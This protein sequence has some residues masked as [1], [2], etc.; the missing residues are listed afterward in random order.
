MASKKTTAIVEPPVKPQ[1]PHQPKGRTLAYQGPKIPMS[2][3]SDKQDYSATPQDCIND[4]RRVA[5]AD[6]EQVISRN[7][8]RNVGKYSES[9]W[10]RFFGTFHEFKRQA[11]IVLTRQQHKLERETAKHAAHDHYRELN[12]IRADYAERFVRVNKSRY[13]TL[14]GLCDIHDRSCDPF[15]LRVALDAVKRIQP[16]VIC[17]NGDLFDLPEFG[18]YTVDP[19]EWDV[20]GRIKFV[21]ENVL[22]PLRKAAPNAQIDLVEGNHEFRLVRHLADNS[23]AMRVVLADLHGMSV[24]TL[25]GLDKFHINYIGKADLAAWR[26]VDI[27]KE[28]ARNYKVYWNSLVAHHFPEGAQLGLPGFCGHHHKHIVWSNTSIA[29]GA[30]EFHQCGAM[31][32]RSASYTDAQ[33]WNNGFII[34]DV[35]TQQKDTVFS[36]VDVRDFAIVGGKYYY[37]QDGEV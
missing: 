36:Y 24:S 25:L 6:P 12:R 10:N 30:Y 29:Y 27:K 14:I 19:R 26:E 32:R 35:D 23:P 34:A 13:Q 20:V 1:R 7:Y 17:I 37:R 8:Y 31:H 18:K 33:K 11:G 5:L 21:H 22:A 15:V 4:L 9:V 2:E 16:D 3:S 28:Q